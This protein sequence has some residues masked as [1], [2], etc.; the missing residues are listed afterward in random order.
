MDGL[1]GLYNGAQRVIALS[2]SK[3]K[4]PRKKI[5]GRGM[6]GPLF[7][8][9]RYPSFVAGQQ[10]AYRTSKVGRIKLAHN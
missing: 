9:N 1:K 4:T 10:K 5:R 8:I 3:K 6:I 7:L 2:V